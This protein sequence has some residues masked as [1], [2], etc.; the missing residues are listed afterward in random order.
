MQ[1]AAR[2]RREQLLCPT[3][4][5][6]VTTRHATTRMA[7]QTTNNTSPRRD[8]SPTKSRGGTKR[9][10]PSQ[11]LGGVLCPSTPPLPPALRPMRWITGSPPSECRGISNGFF[12]QALTFAARSMQH[13]V[14]QLQQWAKEPDLGVKSFTCSILSTSWSICLPY[15]GMVIDRTSN[16]REGFVFRAESCSGI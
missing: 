10:S 13:T 11:G 2:R 3:P 4:G 9:K 5:S 14:N 15:Q 8:E 12:G 6:S 7:R 16:S 1:R